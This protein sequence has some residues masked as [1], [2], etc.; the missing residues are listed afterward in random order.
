[1]F[2]SAAYKERISSKQHVAAPVLEV[3]EDEYAHVAEKIAA[4]EAEHRD[5]FG[6]FIVCWR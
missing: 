5:E 1:M 4:F 3:S 2:D 6:F